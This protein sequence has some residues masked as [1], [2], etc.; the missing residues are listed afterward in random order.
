METVSVWEGY[1]ATYA[2]ILISA[3]LVIWIVYLIFGKRP[4]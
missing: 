3:P 1:I 2:I 4:P